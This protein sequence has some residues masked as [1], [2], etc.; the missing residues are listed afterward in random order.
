MGIMGE[1]SQIHMLRNILHL[2]LIGIWV[3]LLFCMGIMGEISQIHMSRNI[4]H[5]LL[6]GI[7]VYLLFC[8]GIMGPRCPPDPPQSR[9]A[10]SPRAPS[11]ASDPLKIPDPV[12]ALSKLCHMTRKRQR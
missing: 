12:S 6:I 8:M 5:L 9:G 2:L 4:L 3:Y 7:W 11:P 1:I 10:R